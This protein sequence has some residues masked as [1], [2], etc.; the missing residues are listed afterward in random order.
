MQKIISGDSFDYEFIQDSS[1]LN[2]N[3]DKNFYDELKY[4]MKHLKKIIISGGEPFLNDNFYEF[5]HQLISN[6]FSQNLSLIVF[7]NMTKLPKNYKTYYDKF[8]SFKINVSLDAVKKD[9]Y[10]RR[11]TDFKQKHSN[12]KQLQ[13]FFD[14]DYCATV[15]ILNV[16]VIN[17]K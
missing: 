14:I 9:E 10:I 7:S 16:T 2:Y 12:I 6:K 1:K 17:T 3:F 11:G 13:N 8:K 5:I 4:I 15:S